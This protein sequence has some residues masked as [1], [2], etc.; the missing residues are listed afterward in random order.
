METL[1]TRMR[2]QRANL[3]GFSLRKL[4]RICDL[5]PA[6]ISNLE[7]DKQPPG[8]ETLEGILDALEVE[9]GL[10]DEWFAS[11]GIV[12]HTIMEAMVA[13]PEAWGEVRRAL[14]R[15]K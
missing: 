11:A 2:R 1:G 8:E 14:A 10:Y 4:A 13:H 7:N 15:H 5:S 6:H 12:P 3:G 9:P